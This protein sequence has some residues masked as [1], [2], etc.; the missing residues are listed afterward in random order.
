MYKR[1]LLRLL[2]PLV[3]I[4]SL[5]WTAA[6][7]DAAAL[8]A[9]PSIVYKVQSPSERLEM[10]VRTSRILTMDQ[11][12][13]QAQVN[14]PDVLELTPLSPSQIQV[15]AKAVGV[16]QINLWGEDQKV[17]TVDVIV[18]GDARE[19]EMLLRST[20]PSAALKVVPVSNSV[21]ISGFV[22]KPEHI[23]R[24]IRIREAK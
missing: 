7:Q 9:K 1:S 14:N 19:L 6:A 24:I 18:Y 12:I 21:L 20:Y 16:T 22:D 15:S 13:P 8:P 4:T 23:D 5:P 11:K 3:A 2:M 10:T 17:F